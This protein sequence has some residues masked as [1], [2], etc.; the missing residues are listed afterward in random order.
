MLQYGVQVLWSLWHLLSMSSPLCLAMFSGVLLC[1]SGSWAILDWLQRQRPTVSSRI[2]MHVNIISPI[3]LFVCNRTNQPNNIIITY[4]MLLF[5][6]LAVIVIIIVIIIVAIA[7]TLSPHLHSDSD[8]STSSTHTCNNSFLYPPFWWKL[9]MFPWK[10]MNICR[11]SCG[12]VCV[13]G[14]RYFSKG[15]FPYYLNAFHP[16]YFHCRPVHSLTL[17]LHLGSFF[18]AFAFDELHPRRGVS[19]Q[20]SLYTWFCIKHFFGL[21]P[22]VF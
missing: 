9:C 14:R 10:N 11:Y 3:F 18:A 21:L 19:A 17:H 12:V 2:N 7:I 8:P 1:W 16:L 20:K 4:T 5:V 6:V 22:R 15:I 13:C